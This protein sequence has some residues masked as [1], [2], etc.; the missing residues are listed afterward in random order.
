MEVL[1]DP[2]RPD[3]RELEARLAQLRQEDIPCLLTAAQGLDARQVVEHAHRHECVCA[4]VVG[5]PVA[6]TQVGGDP[7]SRLECP[8][9]AAA[10]HPDLPK[11]E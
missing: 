3:W 9:V 11:E 7:W 10:T 5:N 4:V 2:S 6:W 1:A 8:L